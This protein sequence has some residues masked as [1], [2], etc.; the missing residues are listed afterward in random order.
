M[1]QKFFGNLV[2]P[3]FLNLVWK[4]ENKNK[5]LYLSFDDGPTPGLTDTILEILEQYDIPAVFFLEGKKIAEHERMVKS[6]NFAPHKLGNH[7]YNHLPMILA[8]RNFL[9]KEIELA[10]R[11]INTHFGAVPKFF[12]PPYGVFGP[13]L[14][15]LLGNMN[16]DLILWSLMANDF[17]WEKER[18]YEHLVKNLEPG[19]IIVFHNSEE[20]KTV[21]P[22]VLPAF[23]DYCFKNEYVFK[24]I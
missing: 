16:K 21:V 1:G 23:L 11:L 12:R 13:G 22:E 6:W 4:L 5:V 15:H 17:K 10:D 8:G 20:S 9:L 14:Y 24:L 2:F 18:V 7:G 19:D 3:S